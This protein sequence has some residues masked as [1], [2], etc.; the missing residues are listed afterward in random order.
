MSLS[1]VVIVL[2]A[3]SPFAFGASKE[4]MELQR[5]VALLQDQVR[6]LQSS[7]DQK[8]AAI[9]TL[10]Q[11]TLDSVNRTNTAV[12]VMENR[13]NDAMK[14]QQQQLGGPVANVGQKLD[15]MSEDF[16]AVRESVLDMNTRI[17][18]LDAKIADLQNLINTVRTP[19]TPPPG[20][21]TTPAG[22]PPA[23]GAAPAASSGPPNGVQAG[24]LY[25]SAFSDQL[26]GKYDIAFQE[27]T[28]YLKYF[29]N[30]DLAPNAQYAIADIYYRKADYMDAMTAFDAVLEKYPEGAKTPDARYMKAM[31]LEKLGKNDS[32]AREFR[33][34]YSRYSAD[35]PEI[36]AKAK[37]QLR[38]MGLSVGAAPAHRRRTSN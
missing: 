35:R 1:R 30:T 2:F 23:F 18:K 5:D 29:G 36:A 8:V 17:G 10:T 31:C 22:A 15:Q 38:E 14:Q 20:T 13:F 37:A 32:A 26:A 19:A 27:F 25:T 6:T 16:R 28:D 12:A 11:Q 7:L 3:V 9:Q 21:E 34:V 33:E 4:I 24:T